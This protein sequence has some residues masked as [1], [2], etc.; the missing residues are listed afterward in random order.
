MDT[1]KKLAGLI[2]SLGEPGAHCT[3]LNSALL[4]GG[5]LNNGYEL[6]E[7]CA[8]T[9]DRLDCTT[10]DCLFFYRRLP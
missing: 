7:I 3:M 10:G 5:L 6:H 9:I 1:I 4:V 2:S 8:I